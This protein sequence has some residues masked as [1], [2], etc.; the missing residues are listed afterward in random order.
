MRK[1][2]T[3]TLLL[4]SI[5]YAQAQDWINNEST[6]LYEQ[7]MQTDENTQCIEEYDPKHILT[8]TNQSGTSHYVFRL[9]ENGSAIFEGFLADS[10]CVISDIEIFDDSVYFC[11][12]RDVN[13][14]QVGYIG[15]FNIQQFL[16]N[17]NCGYEIMNINQSVKLKKLVAYDTFGKD[18]IVAI[19]SN[20]SNSPIIVDLFPDSICNVF[21]NNLLH[22]EHLIDIAVG[23]KYVVIAGEDTGSAKITLTRFF[24]NDLTNNNFSYHEHN[25]YDYTNVVDLAPLMLNADQ[26]K[27][28]YLDTCMMAIT[29]TA[30]DFN[31]N[32]NQFYTLV[33]V[34]NEHDLNIL[35]TQVIPH[36]DKMIYLKD[37]EYDSLTNKLYILEDNNLDNTGYFT[38]YIL[39]IRPYAQ[40][41]YILKAI[42]PE[43]DYIL[44]DIIAFSFDNKVL[45]VGVNSLLN[46]GLFSKD[47]GVATQHCNQER[48]LKTVILGQANKISATQ[49]NILISYSINWQQNN[50]NLNSS[51][52]ITEC[53]S[54]Y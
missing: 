9:W 49:Y 35:N 23:E 42:K 39:P 12:T 4:L 16:N 30:F 50:F 46:Q 13:G 53:Q 54:N 26:V 51:P 2:L 52:Q 27:I 33:S 22:H 28:T 21:Y 31:N 14:N 17:Q 37:T 45:G 36:N 41:S 34:F 1:I 19:G 24:R 10:N 29:T 38:S 15:R 32:N 8:S 6:L 47:I 40:S 3:L 43:K 25:K 5:T 11:G 7:T 44:N 18:H 20:T 48:M